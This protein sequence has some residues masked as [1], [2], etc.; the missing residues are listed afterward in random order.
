M[1]S[2]QAIAEFKEIYKH[3]FAE[4]ISDNEAKEKGERLLRLFSLI[5]KPIP[6]DWIEII[7]K[8]KGTKE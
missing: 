6:K 3:E 4:D 8:E 1:L 7:L 2:D 5:Y